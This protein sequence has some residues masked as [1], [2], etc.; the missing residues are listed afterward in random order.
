MVIVKFI[1]EAVR[2]RVLHRTIQDIKQRN[3]N[4]DP[5]E[6]QRIVDGA[7]TEVRAERRARHKAKKT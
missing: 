1:E 7:V 6:I 5:E 2:W 3:A 4:A